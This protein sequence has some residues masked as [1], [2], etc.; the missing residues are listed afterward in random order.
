[1]ASVDRPG[2]RARPAPLFVTVSGLKD[3]GKTTVAEALIAGFLARGFRTGGVKSMLHP[4]GRLLDRRGTDTWRL[5][6]AG[7]AFVIGQTRR[8]TMY[9]ERHTAPRRLRELAFL[10]PAGTQLVV[11]E[12]LEDPAAGAWH[13]V[14]LDRPDR[15]EETIAARRLPA[16]RI[17]ALSGRFAHRAPGGPVGGLPAYNVLDPAQREDL[18]DLLL[19][20]LGRPVPGDPPR[21]PLV[22]DP[23]WQPGNPASG[24]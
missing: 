2:A 13:V 15:L 16:G 11:S 24:G 4:P 5:A 19:A 7:A 17:A 1:M 6:R 22:D 9:L 3:T 12:G 18:L 14:C 20:R 21:G 10:F 8:E 23:G